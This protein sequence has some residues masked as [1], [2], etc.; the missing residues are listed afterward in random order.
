MLFR[1]EMQGLKNAL[2]GIKPLLVFFLFSQSVFSQIPI[3][4]FCKYN[5]YKADSGFTNF[6]LI[7]FNNDSYSDFIL[8]NPT[9][10]EVEVIKGEEQGVLK[11]KKIFRIPVE[12]TSIQPLKNRRGPGYFF[13][14]RKKLKAGIYEL[15]TNDSP[16]LSGTIGFDSYPD[17]LSVANVDGKGKNEIL[18]SGSSF[19]GLSIIYQNNKELTEKKIV[20]GTSFSHS[21][22]SDLNNDQFPDIAA[23]NVV[24]RRFELFYNDSKGEFRKVRSIS[25][26]EKITSLK[27]F[28]INLDSYEDLIFTS[29][30]SFYIWYGDFR[31]SYENTTKIESLYKPDKYILGDFNKDGRIDLA[32]LN[33]EHPLVSILFAKNDFEFYPEIIYLQQK[34]LT[35]ISPYY[36]KF[37]DGI[38][39]LSLNGNIHTITNLTSFAEA[40]DISLG[41]KPGALS[42]FDNENNGITD[43]CFIDEYDKKIK[44]ILRNSGGIPANFFSYRLH[45]NHDKIISEN[46]NKGLKN[47]V[48]YSIDKKLIEI[49][50]ADFD[51]NKITRSALYSPGPIKDLK[52]KRINDNEYSIYFVYTNDN[53]LLLG[54]FGY[55]DLK[56]NS[57]E[58]LIDSG[59]FYDASVGIRKEP[60]VF[61]W[62]KSGQNVLLKE[63]HPFISSEA[64]DIISVPITDSLKFNSYTGD[65]LNMDKNVFI[66]FIT[67]SENSYNVVVYGDFSS[68]IKDGQDLANFRITSKNDLFFGETR[69]NGLKRLSIYLP[70]KKEVDRLEF[71][72]KGKNLAFTQIVDQAFIRNF[73][74]KNM[75]SKNYHIV[76]SDKDKY[77]I[78]IRRIKGLR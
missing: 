35:D 57:S 40:V 8:Y 28:D 51:S 42:F 24:K 67:S 17:Y 12:I 62:Q 2:N 27:S 23:Y 10:K 68:M 20:N 76:Y 47:Y 73:F 70:G 19:N 71:I 38:A 53:L 9:K 54:A 26:P 46:L 15:K 5:C 31:S 7:N 3:N 37:I 41:A 32:Y 63:K 14:N 30:K 25:F 60:T 44:F 33:L 48:C 29:G 74:I 72:N 22:L 64:L 43:F 56:F 66:S 69:F 61:Y 77:C 39:A 16:S 50:R 65:L 11:E 58:Q 34:K 75:T 6:M 1:E 4:G 49:I 18:V 13:V 78:T 21:V 55:K 45:E 52:L 36:S 59:K